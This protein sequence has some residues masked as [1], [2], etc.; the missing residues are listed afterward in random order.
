MTDVTKRKCIVSDIDGTLALLDHRRHHVAS[1]PKN[2][3]A[4]FAEIPKDKP[5]MAVVVA[6][7]AFHDQRHYPLILCSGRGKEHAA[8]TIAWIKQHIEEPFGIYFEALYMRELRDHRADDIVKRELLNKMR[9][10][11]WD[12]QL[13][14][15]DRDRVVAMWRSEGI[16]CFQVAPG[17]F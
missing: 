16:P 14:L 13:V 2:W 11:G 6:L 3:K 12:P 7:K 8:V 1:K 15:D 10:D 9:L 4:F 17:D 5:N